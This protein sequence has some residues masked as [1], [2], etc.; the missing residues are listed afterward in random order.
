M[1]ALAAA[2]SSVYVYR[3]IDF[4]SAGVR[5]VILARVVCNTVEAMRV[6]LLYIRIHCGVSYIV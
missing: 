5:H 3:P 1:K 2:E 4:E 6:G